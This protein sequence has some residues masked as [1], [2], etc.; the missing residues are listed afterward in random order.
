LNNVTADVHS[1]RS[2]CLRVASHP[3]V[4]D[5]F[6]TLLLGVLIDPAQPGDCRFQ[7]M[8]EELAKV[9]LA[10]GGDAMRARSSRP[11]ELSAKPTLAEIGI[12]KDQ[13][14]RYQQLAA[15]AVSSLATA[16]PAALA[17][18]QPHTTSLAPHA[19][20]RPHSKAGKACLAFPRFRPF[21]SFIPNDLRHPRR[22]QCIKRGR[23]D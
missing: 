22:S 11:T 19:A 23:R 13:S 7:P 3:Q 12:S 14:S 16:Q 2:L 15:I 5:A 17:C 8:G 6:V 10:T 20:Q 4:E 21:H 18:Y 9:E 1:L